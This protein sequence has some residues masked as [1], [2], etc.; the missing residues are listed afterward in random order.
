MSPKAQ[1]GGLRARFA[2]GV[3]AALY[4]TTAMATAVATLVFP[5]LLIG[6]G[7]LVAL[8]VGLVLL[9][10]VLGGLRRWADVERRRLGRY[11]GESLPERG[12]PLPEG[13]GARLRDTVLDPLTPRD[14]AWAGAHIG[15]GVTL[16]GLGLVAL[17]GVPGTLASTA[18]WWLAPAGEPVTLM[19]VPVT[20]WGTALT[21]G[22]VQCALAAALLL[23]GAKPLADLHARASRALL[24]PSR[25]DR[26]AERVETLTDTR[27]GALNAHA[28]E[29]RRIERDLH[30][31]TQARLVALAMRLGL[32]E[33]TLGEDPETAARLLREAQSG[34][35]EAMTEMR[36]VIRTIYPPILSDR[37]LDGAASAL[38]A[39]S[40]VPAR[41]EAGELGALPAAVE[42]TA[43]FV[44]AEALTNIAKHASASGAEVAIE[45]VGARLRVR[46][47]DDGAGGV[48][49]ERGSGVRGMARRVAA[50]DGTFTVSSPVGGPTTVEAVLPCGS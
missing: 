23:W 13:L 46:V 8:G 11:L 48:D 10:L 49:E 33:R 30:D 1:N 24:S 41:L 5:P 20:G 21:A 15:L 40:V 17:A 9:P 14:L 28:S 12:R 34:A 29:L 42:S 25:A 16:G 6:A 18:L 36:Q 39:R 26:L 47:T 3:R 22:S 50:L 32:A 19:A 2:S 35:E 45:H 38:V 37:G 43:Y 7:S 31:G 44:I 27:A 4:L